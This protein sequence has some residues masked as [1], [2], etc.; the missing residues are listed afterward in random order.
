MQSKII[1]LVLMMLSFSIFHDS[2]F[3][4]IDKNPHTDIV[5]YMDN[6]TKSLECTE[7]NEVHSMCHFIAI[8]TNKLSYKFQLTNREN[9]PHRT[10]LYASFL[11]KTT[12]KPPIA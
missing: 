9:I 4:I 3:A 10:S 5:H 11:K 1:F 7:L 8:I 12:F 6:K 2:F